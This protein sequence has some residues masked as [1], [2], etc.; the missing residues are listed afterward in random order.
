MGPLVSERQRD[1]VCGYIRRGLQEGARAVAGGPEH[2]G[3]GFFVKPTVLVGAG[4]QASVSQEEIF[5]PVLVATP[6]D[7]LENVALFANDTPYGLAASVW[8]NN[9]S[10]VNAAPCCPT[11]GRDRLGQLP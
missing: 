10:K 8:S 5:G 9:L 4:S 11:Q 3:P 1:R 6:F 7:E 2:S